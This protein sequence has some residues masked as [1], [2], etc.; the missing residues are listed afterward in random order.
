MYSWN[1]LFKFSYHFHVL[2]LHVLLLNTQKSCVIFKNS[3]NKQIIIIKKKRWQRQA[4]VNIS[5]SNLCCYSLILPLTVS[6]EFRTYIFF[7]SW[8]V[9]RGAHKAPF[10]EERSRHRKN[11]F[12]YVTPSNAFIPA[13]SKSQRKS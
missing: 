13:D 9:I 12:S 8:V 2:L 5:H 11:P 3:V 7:I 6:L 10:T 4:K 1:K